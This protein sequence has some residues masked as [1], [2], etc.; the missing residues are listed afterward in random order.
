MLRVHAGIYGSP[1]LPSPG[2][3]EIS[4]EKLDEGEDSEALA[5]GTNKGAPTSSITK[6]S[7]ILL[8]CFNTS[9]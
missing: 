9:K 2:A 1:P 5:W 7:D 6:V 4:R 3:S 8:R